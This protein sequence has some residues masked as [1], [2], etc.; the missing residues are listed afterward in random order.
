[1]R[2][3]RDLLRVLE[4]PEVPLHNK[5]AASDIREYVTKRKLSGS[6]RSDSGRRC[7]ETFASL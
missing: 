1:M 2:D 3:H 6:T 5:A 4:R 7:R